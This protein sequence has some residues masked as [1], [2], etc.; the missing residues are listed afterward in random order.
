MLRSLLLAA[1]LFIPSAA[2]AH[3]GMVLPPK[4]MIGKE[5]GREIPVTIAFT[6]PFE[7][8][9]LALERPEVFVQDPEGTRTDL[10]GDLAD[11]PLFG[12]PAYEVN[13]P[14]SRPG[15]Y[16]IAMTPPPY[17]EPAEDVFIVHYT[18]T[19]VAAYGDDTGWDATLDLPTEIVPV[20]RPFG[21]WAGNVFQGQVLIDGEPA[22][23]AEV[24]V[25]HWNTEGVAA[26]DELMITQ[27]IKADGAGIFTYAPP[28]SGW[29][30]FAALSEADYTLPQDGAEKAVELGAVIWVHFEPWS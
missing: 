3:F 17:W 19:Y 5:D 24:E 1:A 22:P 14:L 28:A 2:L 27:T 4:A 9:G 16:A 26:P 25:E 12:E 30:G 13:V 18:K 8:I 6:H 21:L 10:S 29:W 7:G 11:V 15:V 23:F 20:S